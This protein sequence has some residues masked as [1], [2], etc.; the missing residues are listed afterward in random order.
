M[1]EEEWLTSQDPQPLA[2]YLFDWANPRKLRLWACA[3]G[4]EASSSYQNPLIGQVLDLF[5]GVAEGDRRREEQQGPISELQW[6]KEGEQAAGFS[7]VV[8]GIACSQWID[9]VKGHEELFALGLLHLAFGQAYRA[10]PMAQPEGPTAPP[11]DPE[12][13][14]VY[15]TA[16]KKQ[17]AT[18]RDIFNN[19]FR[20]VVFD[21]RWRTSTVLALAEMSYADR[22]FDRLPI[23]ADA[24]QDAGC[25]HPDVLTHCRGPGPH[26][27]G[28]WVIDGILGKS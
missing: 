16:L 11:T 10:C 23:L 3:C 13:R 19:P 22:A 8:D 21:S 24:L 14:S 6:S 25:E 18:A 28:C 27:R 15:S 26:A 12:W 9:M 4:R 1:T 17:S 5:E 2:V 20:P 7:Q